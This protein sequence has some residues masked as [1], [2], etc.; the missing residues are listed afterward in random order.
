MFFNIT[1]TFCTLYLFMSNIEIF[2]VNTYSTNYPYTNY[3]LGVSNYNYMNFTP[4]FLQSHQI[5]GKFWGVWQI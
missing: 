4:G 3:Q 1:L 5:V 2:S